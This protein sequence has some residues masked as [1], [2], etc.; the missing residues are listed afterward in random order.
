MDKS[1]LPEIDHLRSKVTD[2]QL[3]AIRDVLDRN[4]DVFRNIRQ[5]LDA[6]I[7]LRSRRYHIE[8]GRGV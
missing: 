6:V 5:T 7:L 8:R 4:Q 1:V 2:E 3:E